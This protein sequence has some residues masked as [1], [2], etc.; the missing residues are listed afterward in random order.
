MSLDFDGRVAL[1]TGGGRGIGRGIAM[2][3]ASHGC[4]VVVNSLSGSGRSPTQVRNTASEVVEEIREAGGI[5][6]VAQGDVVSEASDI[7]ERA[8]SAFGQLDIVINNAGGLAGT[9]F[10]DTPTRIWDDVAAVHYRG[11]V[12]ISRAAWPHLVRSGTGRIINVSSSAILGN[13]WTTS[14][15]SAKAGVIGFARSLAVEAAPF[16]IFVNSILPTAWTDMTKNVAHPV[17]ARILKT[18]FQANHV[19]AFVT[20]LVHQDTVV[21]NEIFSVGGGQASR[22]VFAKSPFVLCRTPTPENWAS[23]E[24]E[25]LS[26]NEF[27]ALTS[28]FDLLKREILSVDPSLESQLNDEDDVVQ[29]RPR[30][31]G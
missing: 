22:I 13:S 29:E 6:E 15:G 8:I 11:T 31:N 12:A 19:G 5:A 23:R 2:M 3:L 16:G 7:V 10:A 25:L 9:T 4:R 21:T 17:I 26:G 30:P 20:W 14:Y 18:D 1:V 28:T 27:V 24:A